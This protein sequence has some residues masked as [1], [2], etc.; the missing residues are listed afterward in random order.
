MNQQLICEHLARVGIKAVIAQDGREGCDL[1]SGRH[2]TGSKPFDLILMD[3]HMPV[4]SG[5]EAAA[6][7]AEMGVKTPIVALSANVMANVMHNDLELYRRGGVARCLGK[8]FT[9]QELWRCLLEYLEPLSL[10]AVDRRIHLTA[11]EKL[12]KHLE[13]N[14]VK[15]NR[16]TC[17]ELRE[18]VSCGNTAL[19]V[20]I[21]H[22]LKSNAAQIGEERLRKAAAAAEEMLGG[23][24]I[25]RIS[26]AELGE[27]LIILEE[28]AKAVLDRLALLESPHESEHA[29]SRESIFGLIQRLEPML[30]FHNPEC[31]NLLD[32]INVMKSVVGM[33][34][35]AHHVEEFEFKK[36]I[37]TLER[38]KAEGNHV[39]ESL[40]KPKR[41]QEDKDV[42]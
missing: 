18:A 17:D 41:R 36:A 4:M 35:L 19:A 12:L 37:V 8:P 14:F 26:M 24:G 33:E 38:I 16:H 15:S 39:T 10:T 13:L 21:A 11:E 2:K 22:T 40:A 28:E 25:G 32:E 27:C 7:I 1:V 29:V 3:I 9:S 42:K 23:V 31:M 30:H 6:E 20:R 5:L 34:E